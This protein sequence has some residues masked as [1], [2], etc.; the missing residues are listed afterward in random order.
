MRLASILGLVSFIVS[1]HF[2]VNGIFFPFVAQMSE[3]LPPT[4]CPLILVK[5]HGALKKLPNELFLFS[6]SFVLRQG[7]A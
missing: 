2:S 1:F 5:P 6:L 3:E 4:V 7:L